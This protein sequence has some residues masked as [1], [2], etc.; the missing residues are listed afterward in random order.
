MIG[1]GK[2]SVSGTAELSRATLM[3][4]HGQY[5]PDA[6][7]AFAS[8][9]NNGQCPQNQERDLHRW[10]GELFGLKLRTYE[11]PMQLQ[12]PNQ[13]GVATIHIPF[14]LPH[15]TIHYIAESSDWQFSRSM[16]G[17]RSGGEISEFWQHCK[18]HIEWAD[19]PALADPEVPTERLIPLNIHMDGAE[20][21]SNSE[22]NVWS[23]GLEG[24]L[25]GFQS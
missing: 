5:P 2:A 19:H 10:L 22:F 14:L 4:F 15:E 11:V 8:L 16:T 9:G 6:L 17:G 18:K 12:V 25:L 3:D 20:F 13:P 24:L 1:A 21:Y 23:I 7:Q